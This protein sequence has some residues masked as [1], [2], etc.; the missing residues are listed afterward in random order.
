METLK[1]VSVGVVGAGNV[2]RILLER[3]RAAGV[4]AAR[5]VVYD[6]EPARARAAAEE[7]G[8][9]VADGPSSSELWGADLVLLAAP[10]PTILGVVEGAAGTLREGQTVVSF[11][12]GVRLEWLEAALP[13]GVGAARVMP[14]APSKVGRGFNP[15]CW[16]SRLGEPGRTRVRAVLDALGE[17]VEVPEAQLSWWVGLSGAAMRSLLPVL[18]GMVDA[19][20]EAGL[21]PA[22]ARRAAIRQFQGTAAL[23]EHDPRSLVEL[24]TLTPMETL[25][26][27][28]VRKLFLD[29]ARSARDKVVQLEAKVG[30]AVMA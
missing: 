14:N 16:G 7:T 25:D 3:L 22:L 27:A 13:A 20:L 28:A 15:V 4:G 21:D 29:A 23:A 19:G 2:G 18:E 17:S 6:V 1:G 26:E 9:R 30:S 8:A 12:A 24:K 5:I 10:P 11:A